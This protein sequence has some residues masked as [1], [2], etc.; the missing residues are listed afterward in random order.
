MKIVLATGIYP[1]D[2]GGPASYT[3]KMAHFLRSDGHEVVVI[4]Y[5]DD[6]LPLSVRG[7]QGDHQTESK[8]QIISRNKNILF[9]YLKFAWAVFREARK[10]DIIYAQGADAAGFPAAIAAKLTGTD[11]VIKVVGDYGWERAMQKNGLSKFQIPDSKFQIPLLD[12]YLASHPKGFVDKVERWTAKRAKKIIVPSRYLK[13]VVERWG[14]PSERIRVVKNTARDRNGDTRHSDREDYATSG[15]ILLSEEGS[16]RGVYPVPRY[17]G[18]DDG[19]VVARDDR[20]KIIF[21]AA[22]RAVPWKGIAELIEWWSDLPESHVLVVAGDGPE[23]ERWKSM[24]TQNGLENRVRFLGR[25]PGAELAT[26]YSSA[27][28]FILHSG[29]EGY[30]HV[31]PEAVSFGLPCFVSDQG[32]NPETKEDFP[33]NITVLPYRDREAWVGALSSFHPRPDRGTTV[34]KMRTVGEMY[35]ET[36]PILESETD[37]IRTVMVSYD[38]ALLDPESGVA[39]RVLSIADRKTTI[40]PIVISVGG[41]F[42]GGSVVR[43]WKAVCVGIR[44][45]RKLPDRTVVTAQ[46]P[47]AAGFVGYCIS[48]WTN[49]PLEIQEHGDFYSGYWEKESWKNRLLSLC[50][51]FILRRAERVRAVSERIKTDL[52]RIGIDEKKID[53]IPVSQEL[54]FSD[55]R[56]QSVDVPRLI[57]PCRFVKQKGLDTLIEAARILKER[58]VRFRLDLIG[59]GFEQAALEALIQ[60]YRLQNAIRILPWM[61]TGDLWKGADLFVLSSRYEGWGR[62]IVEAMAAGIPIVTTDVGCVGSFFRPQIDGRVVQP[63][64]PV[65]L[66]DVIREQLTEHDRRIALCR[67]ARRRAET[68]AT[69]NELHNNQRNGWDALLCAPACRIEPRWDLWVAA[70]LVFVVL[71]RAASVAL[72]HDSLVHRETSIFALVTNWLQGYGYSFSTQAGCVSAYRSPGYLFF[73]T[74]LYSI[75]RP[76]NTMA[77]AIVQNIFVVGVLWLV[78]VVGKRL[79][80]KRAA[81]IGGFLMAAYPYTF[82]HYTQYY[83]TFLSSFFL[84]LLVWFLLRLADGERWRNAIGAG[85]SIAILAFVQGTILPATPFFVLW[86]LL[87]WW[88]DW[89]R[90]LKASVIMAIVSIGLIAPWTY[91][92]WIAFDKFV[93][94]TTDLGLAYF[95]A[96]SENIEVFFREGHSID[97]TAHVKIPSSTNPGYIMYAPVEEGI[98]SLDLKPSILWTEWHQA[99]SVGRRETCPSPEWM[100][101]AELNEYWFERIKEVNAERGFVGRT[102]LFLL[103][104]RLFWSPSLFPSVKRGAPWSFS[105]SALKVWLARMSVTVAG[106]IVIFLGWLGLVYRL[107][108]RRDLRALLPLSILLVYTFM[109]GLFAPYTK[110]RIPIDNLMAVYAGYVIILFWDRLRR[111]E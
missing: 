58:G 46:D 80:G 50:G 105:D 69:T 52:I 28:A 86:L 94:L 24:A 62:T 95:K 106:T 100:N 10:A 57:A 71:S 89:K 25:L 33:D 72:F 101:E 63:N 2:I 90:S 34:Q 23:L 66:A 41:S 4:T 16:L 49:V 84:L 53:I 35:E 73:L 92:N 9:R 91:R 14:V 43:I 22:V 70:F 97:E 30:P 82:Y 29:Y 98:D 65:A 27:D 85:L 1:P 87:I 45:A 18:R 5:G 54:V 37:R 74:A 20:E 110:Y 42:S 8:I 19:S 7:I 77:Q 78:Y 109:H 6:Q 60:K 39:K 3:S 96:N 13:T 59:E 103:K 26:W 111:R 15:G 51:R 67:S 64:D 104:T 48:R 88:P 31:I 75:F 68:L 47:F 21:F 55:C 17:G 32:G 76:E 99:G 107:I 61:R 38:R 40:V 79:V 36:V 81:L 108:R 56:E 12:E 93:P 44:E 83:H 11:F 102:K